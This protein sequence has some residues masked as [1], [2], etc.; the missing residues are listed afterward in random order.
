MIL[1][2]IGLPGEVLRLLLLSG[3]PGGDSAAGSCAAA[4]D[5]AACIN[6]STM[7][8]QVSVGP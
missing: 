8:E 3:S 4:A 6:R 5:A 7:S 1:H 2:G